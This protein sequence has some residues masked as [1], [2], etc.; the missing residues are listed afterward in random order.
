LALR[1]EL[2]DQARAK[3]LHKPNHIDVYISPMHYICHYFISV[4]NLITY[5]N[6]IVCRSMCTICIQKIPVWTKENIST[7]NSYHNTAVY[8]F[9]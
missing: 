1:S 3:G 2:Y 5:W 8:I 6:T 4:L 9:L 7:N